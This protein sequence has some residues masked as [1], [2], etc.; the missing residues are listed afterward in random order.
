MSTTGLLS[1][2]NIRMKLGFGYFWWHFLNIQS[3]VPCTLNGL[4]QS[5]VC[6]DIYLFE[7]PS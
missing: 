7:A 2:G 4:S 1:M 6:K 3:V 5:E